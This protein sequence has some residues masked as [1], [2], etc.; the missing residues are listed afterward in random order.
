MSTFSIIIPVFNEA[1]YIRQVI[2]AVDGVDVGPLSKEIIVVDDGSS[3]G[4]A[5]ILAGLRD[6]SQFAGELKVHICE[7]NAGKGAA[8]RAGLA[9]ATG[10]IIAIQDADLELDPGEFPSLLKPILEENVEAVYGS[11]FLRR[12]SAFSMNFLGNWFLTRLTNLLF[13]CH[14]TD[15]ETAYKVIRGDVLRGLPLQANRFDI[16]PEITAW[17]C[18]KGVAIVEV[19]VSYNPRGATMGKKIRYTDGFAAVRCL[20]RC[21]FSSG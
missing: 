6:D 7:R 13:R 9:M 21:R 5:E 16:E 8:V 20:I 4:T 15:M 18:R 17:L 1:R 3:D 11:R 19:P 14:L 2:E 10:D 12:S